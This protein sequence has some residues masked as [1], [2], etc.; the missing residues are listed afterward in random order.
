MNRHGLELLPL[1][2]LV[3]AVPAG[4]EPQGAVQASDDSAYAE[5]LD[6]DRSL[7]LAVQ[8]NSQLLS[9]EQ[10]VIIAQQRVKEARLHFLPQA[11]LGG[12]ITK[13]NVKYPQVLQADFG[14]H[15]IQPSENENFFTTTLRMVQP[16]Y[17]GGRITNTYRLA[18]AALQQARTKYD[19]VKR[20]VAFSL[21][22]SFYEML[23]SKEVSA[24]AVSS[25]A[26]ARG[27]AQS[28]KLEDWDEVEAFAVLSRM[29]GEVQAASQ[30]MRKDRL[31]MLKA[32]N[33]ELNT[34][35]EIVGELKPDPVSIDLSKAMVWAME[36]RPEL[37]GEAYKAEMD[38]IAVN[39]AMSRRSPTVMLGASYD[40]AGN[41]FPLT[42]N[43]W[44]TTLSVQLP[45]S[46]D[47]WPQI[48]QRRAEQ[49]QGD[50]NRAG[51]QD[52]VRLEVRHAHEE[53]SYW[54]AEVDSRLVKLRSLEERFSAVSAKAKP[55]LSALRAYASRYELRKSYLE[56]VKNQLSARAR[57]EWALVHDLSGE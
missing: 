16:I 54:Q 23:Y 41:S 44:E 21:K 10:D 19:A 43:S 11:S 51:I 34:R 17:V 6:M 26:S 1:L 20:D 7:R 45:L 39:L 33:K 48:E 35:I 25:L 5:V 55:S 37:K 56:A 57:L 3:L 32:L 53:M 42:S 28:L 15:I 52:R 24:A 49:R 8:N 13:A 22:Q 31:A 38:A 9:A 36:L 12:T 47:F 2:A 14:E 40:V 30:E 4:A 27:V 29:E 50:L 18:Q 46:F